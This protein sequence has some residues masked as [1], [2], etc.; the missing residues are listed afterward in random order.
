MPSARLFVRVFMFPGVLSSLCQGGEWR[1]PTSAAAWQIPVVT[2]AEPLV[3]QARLFVAAN[4]AGD[5]AAAAAPPAASD[6]KLI[7]LRAM[8]MYGCV[9]KTV[10]NAEFDVD[11]ADE[12]RVT[13][14]LLVK[15]SFA[16][17][18]V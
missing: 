12:S 4:A 3:L 8:A 5:A 7:D 6:V 11:G 17:L 1:A 18:A 10:T 9:G 13:S 2:A 14:L 15:C 16:P